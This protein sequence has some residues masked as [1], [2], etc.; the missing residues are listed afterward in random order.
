MRSSSRLAVCGAILFALTSCKGDP[1]SIKDQA[2]ILKNKKAELKQRLRAVENLEKIGKPEVV[3]ALV[4]AL[5]S[6]PPKLKGEIAEALAKFNEPTSIQP[7]AE[8]LELAPAKKQSEADAANQKMVQALA[9]MG[10]K[11]AVPG[12]L[13]LLEASPS[14]YVKFDVLTAL[15]KI[16]GTEAVPVLSKM[17]LDDGI[18]A[19]FNKKAFTA[20]SLIAPK[21][22][23]PVFMKGLFHNRG[24]L[25]MYPDACF[26]LFKLRQE[27]L[28][29]VLALMNGKDQETLDYAKKKEIAAGTIA[30]ITAQ[31]AGHLRDPRMAKILIKQLK[32]KDADELMTVMAQTAAVESLGRMRAKAAVPA[33]VE[34]LKGED[35]VKVVLALSRIGDRSVLPKLVECS[36]EGSWIGREA[37]IQGVV[38]L[39]GRA[40]AKAFD[41]MIKDEPKNFLAEC[42]NGDYGEV[43]CNKEKD[44]VNADRNKSLTSYKAAL[45]TVGK[46][47][48]ATDSQCLIAALA[49]PDP[50]VRE[51]AAYEAAFRRDQGAL[52]A[53]VGAILR[54]AK[55]EADLVP[56]VAAIL[57]VDWLVGNDEVA[58]S[59]I[60]SEVPKLQELQAAD[61]RISANAESAE[62]VQ[63]L[64]DVIQRGR[65]VAPPP[66]EPPDEGDK[67]AVEE[68][69][70]EKPKPVAKPAKATTRKKKKGR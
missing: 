23:I 21:E 44:Q 58:R 29:P 48:G 45:E 51:K 38:A 40:E 8:A 25:S 22:A 5:P 63:R 36:T 3:P 60:A 27:A 24:A 33:L 50:V 62:E 18:E 66:D 4:A 65:S 9:T 26:G 2:K 67:A 46:C 34:M 16:G 30:T 53:L 20:L 10:G 37:C 28:D 52:P 42:K 55:A 1:N 47:A 69:P 57:A 59:K 32:Y 6:A 49:H 39:G 56:R 41:A 31:V 70:A 64:I 13:K 43:D 11:S 35:R 14:N 19:P 15:G 7:L 68:K 17:A 12:L 54:P 61:S